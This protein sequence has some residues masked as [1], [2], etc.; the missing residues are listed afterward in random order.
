M[1]ASLLRLLPLRI[2][3]LGWA[4]WRSFRPSVEMGCA[5]FGPLLCAGMI[6]ATLPAARAQDTAA[7]TTL[8]VFTGDDGNF[9]A[10][11]LVQG[12]DGNFYGSTERG[13][14]YGYGTIFQ[15]TPAG[16]LTILHSFDDM[17]GSLP[18][19]ALVVG[20]DGNF[21]GTCEGGGDDFGDGTVFQLTPAGVL[22]TLHVFG[23][24]EGANPTGALVQG[25][26][27]NFYGATDEGGAA[28]SG[29]LFRITPAGM[30][31]TF[32]S[33]TDGSDGA[34]ASGLLLGRDGNFY[35][36]TSL[37]GA[38]GD[39]LNG[40]GTIYQITP[41][42]ALTAFYS[43]P[44]DSDTELT[45]VS[46]LVQDGEGNFY[47]T[48]SGTGVSG[49]YGTV[50]RITPAGLFA[51]L[52]QFSGTDG[53][54]PSGL[55]F[56]GYNEFYGTTSGGGSANAGTVFQM[57]LGG[58]F[59][60]LYSF[61]GVDGSAPQAGVVQGSDGNF[62]GTTSAGGTGGMGTIFKLS[63]LPAFFTGEA[64]LGDGAYFLSLPGGYYFGF[65]SF[66]NEPGY[67]YHF[68]LGYEYFIDAADGKKGIYLYDFASSDFFYTSPGF[69]F[70]YLYDF[71]LKSLV[72][73]YPDPNNAGHYNTDGVRYFYVFNTGQIISK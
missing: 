27:G 22:T 2:L 12:V 62:Y 47:G 32:H 4:V 38:D 73:Y 40:G 63:V 5:A 52:H 14:A 66:L 20:S 29:T 53:S 72:Y 44:P 59:A 55:F 51:T 45:S 39:G 65:Y 10:A 41:A 21:Y 6:L 50:F 67:L 26:D 56:D 57:N 16:G 69:P 9:P 54:A 43:F 18:S 42:G 33:F 61:S 46:A 3:A 8:H 15:V 23:F 1:K 34:S 37:G 19:A 49:D 64:A 17:D 25:Q 28:Y 24:E 7:L 31:T 68:D 11:P 71:N 36:T 13:G 48:T 30:L 35:G 60:T 70:P 58:V